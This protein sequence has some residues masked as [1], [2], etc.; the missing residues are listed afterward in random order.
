MDKELSLGSVKLKQEKG[1]IY[2]IAHK[3]MFRGWNLASIIV[4]NIKYF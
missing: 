4:R 3:K 1:N 2:N